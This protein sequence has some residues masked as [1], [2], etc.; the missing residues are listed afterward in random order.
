MQLPGHL[1]AALDTFI[2][3]SADYSGRDEVIADAVAGFLAEVGVAV[4]E[5]L[6]LPTLASVTRVTP[7]TVRGLEPLQPVLAAKTLEIHA[8][9]ERTPIVETVAGLPRE[10]FTWGLHNRD[11]P[12]LWATYHLAM[13]SAADGG[14]IPFPKWRTSV[15]AD[16]WQ[17]AL[18]LADD[19]NFDL[20]GFPTNVEKAAK[21]EARFLS[22]FVGNP[23]GT[24]PIFDL[25]LAGIDDDGRCA[26]TAAGVEV[27]AALDG[28][29]SQ[30]EAETMAA[31][32][33]AWIG[34]LTRWAPAD[35]SLFIVVVKA[36]ADGHDTRDALLLAVAGRYQEWT[37]SQVSTN[38]AA[39]VSRLRE[40][41]LIERRQRA[42][43]YVLP[44]PKRWA[45]SQLASSVSSTK[46]TA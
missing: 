20:S 27:L 15:A 45:V 43:R 2:N 35:I 17:V 3:G 33:E 32:R 10:Q 1:V 41:G 30:V 9:P 29:G 18:G 34:H 36:I 16:A 46:E 23:D 28:W 8:A 11:F 40:V 44:G 12:T 14:P 7:P 22:F 26:P 21:A 6:P 39:A 37:E 25:A 4:T 19:S 42:G 31:R 5:Q 38:T 13:A 24:G